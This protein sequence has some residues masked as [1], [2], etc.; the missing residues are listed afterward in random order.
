MKKPISILLLFSFILILLS[1]GFVASAQVVFGQRSEEVKKIQEI[2]K[3]DPDIYPEGY[4]TGYFG[5]LTRRAIERLQ[6]RCKLPETGIIDSETEK[7]IYPIGYKIKVISPNGGEVWDRNETHTITWEVIS[8]PD[9][10]QKTPPILPIWPMGSIDLFRR[11]TCK[12]SIGT[13]CKPSVE[14]SIFVRHLSTVNLFER[15]WTYKITGDVPNGSDYVIRISTGGG[16][17]PI[18]IQERGAA[19]GAAIPLKSSEIWGIEPLPVSRIPITWDESDGTFEIT[20]KIIPTI[21]PNLG[22]VIAILEKIITELQRAIALLR[23]V[24]GGANP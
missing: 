21:C 7:C 2:L 24:E 8:P 17:L 16:I 1:L 6:K 23:G 18:W 19:P 3:T 10:P 20:G 15:A 11:I 13:T 22:E 4:V 9:L 5:P 12:S 14:Q